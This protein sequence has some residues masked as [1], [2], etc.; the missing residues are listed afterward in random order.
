MKKLVW[1]FMSAMAL[2]L[3]ISCNKDDEKKLV[4]GEDVTDSF[5]NPGGKLMDNGV[6]IV[7]AWVYFAG[8]VNNEASDFFIIDS[9]GQAKGYS[10][11]D[12]TNY[13]LDN[14]GIFHCSYGDFSYVGSSDTKITSMFNLLYTLRKSWEDP[15]YTI[16]K[17]GGKIV[18][19]HFDEI[20]ADFTITNQDKDT[21]IIKVRDYVEG[22]DSVQY[23]RRVKGFTE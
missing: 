6:N 16:V 9:S 7:G 20:C 4:G 13:I 23:I 19:Y 17:E 21:F 22:K 11:N 14:K 10:S 12:G 5:L 8:K 1:L 18:M 3:A 15:D 2:S